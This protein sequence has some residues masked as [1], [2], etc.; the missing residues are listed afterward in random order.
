MQAMEWSEMK[1]MVQERAALK[2]V[3]IFNGMSEETI[4]FTADVWFDG[5]LIGHADN[6]GTG[7]NNNVTPA[8]NWREVEPFEEWCQSL[9]SVPSD[10][11]GLGDLTMSS[12][13]LL[14]LW[15]GDLAEEKEMRRLCKN[16]VIVKCTDG[17]MY[18]YRVAYS[19]TV[20]ARLRS[21]DADIVE[22]INE[23]F[24]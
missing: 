15:I 5:K 22:I 14:S 18:T 20:A 6:H 23:R 13:F 9:P 8:N 11:D 2:K 17:E 7:G 19:P 10:V 3:K 16:K 12:D 24:L 4:A 21:R 1:S